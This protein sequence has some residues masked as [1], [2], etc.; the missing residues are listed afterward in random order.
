MRIVFLTG[1][2]P[3][4]VG[5]PATHGPDFARFL[6]DRGHD[7]HVVTMADG[8]PSERPVPVQTVARG[9]PFVIRYPQ[10]ALAGA[11]PGAHA[12]TSSTRPRRMPRRGRGGTGARRPLVAKLVSDP[13]YERAWRYGLFRGSL[14]EF[15]QAGDPRSTALR[16]LRTMSLRRARRIVVPSRYLAEIAGGWGLDRDRIEV[17]VNPAPAPADVEPAP[18]EP[19]TFV[20]VG[21]LTH[22][23]ALPVLLEAIGAVDGARLELVGDG[24]DRA[25]LE[26]MVAARGLD[27]RVRFVGALPRDQVLARLA[28]ARAA[29]LSSA[30]E[31]LPHAA[32]EALSVGTPVVSTA[33]GGVPEVVRDGENGLL[34][35]PND[36]AALAGA[37]RAILHDDALRARLAAAA[38]PSVAAI[39]RDVIYGR[40]EQILAEAAAMTPRVLFV[41]RG[42]LSLPLAPWLQ[43]KW[44]ALAEVLDLRV[45]NAGT[46]SGDPRFTAAPRRRSGVLP[47]A[48]ARGCP[49][50]ARVPGRRDRRVR[51]VRRRRSARRAMARAVAGPARRRGARRSADVHPRLRLAGPPARARCRP[52]QSRGPA[53]GMQTRRARSPASRRR[54]SRRS[55]GARRPRAS[56]P[57]ATWRRSAIRR[58]CPCPRSRGSCSSAHSRRT[59]TST[60]LPP[61]GGASPR[62]TR[63]PSS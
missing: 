32:V 60:A 54:S 47:A 51:P 62:V 12:P 49:L 36:P 38:K 14:E 29:V 43:R 63:T 9:R 37:L 55:P 5:G 50:A 33:V 19:G 34:V 57:T 44:D 4:D 45:L 28:G 52:T 27:D 25:A 61:P 7:V 6:R 24:A 1:I 53:S 31:N 41:G 30:W 15:Q 13:A 3:P 22:Q 23:K 2:W 39:G 20:F 46:G 35:P 11:S 26:S 40:L 10:V 42:R 58:S 17:L 56:R 18:L 59:R 16:R 48:A 21:R 8:E